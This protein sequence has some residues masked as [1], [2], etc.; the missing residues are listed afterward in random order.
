MPFEM[1]LSLEN[2]L[3]KMRMPALQVQS[4]TLGTL[5]HFKYSRHY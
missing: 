3:T 1:R 4:A 5:V 2:V